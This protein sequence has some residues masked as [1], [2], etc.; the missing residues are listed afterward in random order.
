MADSAIRQ[1]HVIAQHAL[2]DRADALDGFLRAF[3]AQVGFQLHAD[4]AQR[5]EGMFQQ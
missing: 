5:L 3:V 4:T 2:L 1:D